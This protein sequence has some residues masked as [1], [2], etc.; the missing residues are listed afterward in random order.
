MIKY[1]Y[2][3]LAITAFFLLVFFGSACEESVVPARTSLG[4]DYF[5]LAIG[6]V[7]NY[8][9]DSIVLRNQVGGIFFDSVHLEAQEILKDTLRDPSG[10]LW[11]RGERYDR[12]SGTVE[13]RFRQ[14]F[15]L[16]QDAQRAYRQEDN[17]EFVKLIFPPTINERWNGHVAFDQYRSID[18]AG[19]PIEIFA[20]WDYRYLTV[21]E[22][23]SVGDVN[24]DSLLV[25]EGA[26]YE[27]LL[28]RRLS[29]ETY[30]RHIGLVYRELEVFETQC[31]LCCNG[32]TGACL[33]LPWR[34]KAEGGFILR[35]WRI[36]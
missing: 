35:Q 3:L 34:E 31:Q 19:E 5:P 23:G 22:A 26:D 32:D 18:V 11:Y 14:T 21:D 7:T 12:R 28:N 33:D 20:D 36:Q 24:Y 16:R 25:V 17:L 6:D 27:N 2:F 10:Q 30:A 13:W 9:L 29:I 15:L 1:L 8:E 4:Y